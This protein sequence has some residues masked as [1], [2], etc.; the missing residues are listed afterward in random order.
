MSVNLM[1]PLSF[2]ATI[3][4][5]FQISKQASLGS[6]IDFYKN[7][8]FKDIY[9]AYGLKNGNKILVQLN[10]NLLKNKVDTGYNKNLAAYVFL[11]DKDGNLSRDEFYRKFY[12]RGL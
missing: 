4:R 6:L 8:R 3:F 5:G 11:V 9:I 12:K 7:R 1:M 10:Q 2:I